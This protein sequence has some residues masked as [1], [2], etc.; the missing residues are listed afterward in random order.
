MKKIILSLAIVAVSAMIAMPASAALEFPTVADIEPGTLIKSAASSTVYYFGNDELRYGFPNEA[1]FFTWYDDFNSVQ[2][3]AVSEMDMIAFSGM[4]TYRP[5]L[6]NEGATTRLL[7][8]ST[9]SE[10]YVPVGSNM[11][12]AVKNVDNANAMF[13]ED[14]TGLVDMLPNEF[15][16]HYTVLSGV[17]ADDVIFIDL[18]DYTISDSIDLFS[19]TGVMMYEDPLRFAAIDEDDDLEDD[20]DNCTESYCGYNVLTVSQGGTIKF[21]NYTSE[22]LTV[23]ESDD[24]LFTTGKIE[25]EEIIVLTIDLEPGEYNFRADEDWD[26][27]GVLIVE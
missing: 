18:N 9:G 1:T 8:L 2:T 7:K 11:L 16:P 21:V 17:L 6:G 24:N 5:Q 23:R 19:A 4:V 15:I 26:M 14:W 12:A 3:I 22:T 25:P 13:G 20:G 27:M 10:V